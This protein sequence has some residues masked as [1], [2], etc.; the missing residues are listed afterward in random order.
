MKQLNTQDTL[1][2][3]R[4]C[5][6]GLCNPNCPFYEVEE[7]EEALAINALNAIGQKEREIARLERRLTPNEVEVFFRAQGELDI[8]HC[9]VC[10]GEVSWKHHEL[11]LLVE[12]KPEYCKHCGQALKW[13]GVGE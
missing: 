3:L 5:A 9:P 10:D 11:E 1:H 8:Y 13:K 12:Q 4:I 7:C 6:D 2:A